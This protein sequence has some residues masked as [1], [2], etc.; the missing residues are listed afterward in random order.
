[1]FVHG[2][3]CEDIFNTEGGSYVGKKSSSN[4]ADSVLQSRAIVHC[5]LNSRTQVLQLFSS[6]NPMAESWEL[7]RVLQSFSRVR[8]SAD[9]L[10]R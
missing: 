10:S 2:D 3:C 7:N 9:V 8:W 1:M 4:T 5:S 6:M